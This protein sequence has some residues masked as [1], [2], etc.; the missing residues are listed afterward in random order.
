M[1]FSNTEL[2]TEIL[3]IVNFILGFARFVPGEFGDKLR[4]VLEFIKDFTENQPWFVGL[5]VYILNT[6]W[7]NRQP[8]I[9]YVSQALEHFSQR[10]GV[11]G[12]PMPEKFE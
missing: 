9:I 2:K 11:V 1:P 4:E 7:S 10:I 5:L 6:F 8:D 12:A 3:K